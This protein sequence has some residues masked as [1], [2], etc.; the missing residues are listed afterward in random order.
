MKITNEMLKGWGAC[1]DGYAWFNKHFPTGEAEYQ[2]ILDALAADDQ[3]QYAHWLMD[4][5]GADRNAVLEVDA[6][7]NCKNLFFAG[8]IVIKG[9]ATIARWLRAGTGIEAGEGIKA[10]WGIKAGEGIK[11]GWG[12]EAGEGIKAGWGIEAGEG[13]KAGWGIEAGSD[14]GIFAGLRVRMSQ[15]AMY[16]KV[17][18]KSKPD[19]LV[20]GSWVEPEGE[21]EAA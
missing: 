17:T 20:S 6:I 19:N 16:A 11:A 1:S 8:R 10:G 14:Y 2:V 5:A 21:K 15:W 12:I 7:V 9:S 13:I 3:P 18:A 4:H